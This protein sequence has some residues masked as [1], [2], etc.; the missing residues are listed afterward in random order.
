MLKVE[1]NIRKIQNE[2]R[3]RLFTEATNA[4]PGDYVAQAGHIV[5]SQRPEGI[6]S[7]F[8]PLNQYPPSQRKLWT[9]R[10]F[11]AAGIGLLVIGAYEF[12]PHLLQLESANLE[13]LYKENGSDNWKGWKGTNDWKIENRRLINEGTNQSWNTPTLIAPHYIA[14]RNYAVEATIQGEIFGISARGSGNAQNW[15]GYW[16]FMGGAAYYNGVP[17]AIIENNAGSFW[18]SNLAATPFTPGIDPHLYRL[19]VKDSALRLFIDG[20]HVVE[21]NNNQF[22]TGGQVGLGTDTPII[23]SNFAIYAI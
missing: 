14:Q 11:I 2:A 20:T 3:N 19:E 9:R 13:T 18:S 21:T 15:Q 6:P 16:A 23:V 4:F 22:P 17:Q 1:M 10:A 7:S 12:A 8:T 5:A